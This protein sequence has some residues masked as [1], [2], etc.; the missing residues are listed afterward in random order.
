MKLK[1]VLSIIAMLL[2]VF[3]TGCE[4][5]ID[6][7]GTPM[8]TSTNPANNSTQVAINRMV[9]V[10]FSEPMDISTIT[11]LTFTLNQGST[12]V[13]GIV[14][15]TGTSATF[16][17]TTDLS[18]SKIYSGTITTGVKNEAGVAMLSNHTFIFTTG[19]AADNILPT[20]ISN[21]PLNNATAVG[22][23]KGVS[24]NFSEAMDPSTLNSSF[25]LKQGTTA[26]PG[27]VTYTGSTATFT[28]TNVLA[29]STVYTATVTTGAKDLAGNALATNIVWSFTTS[30]AL[31]G[32]SAVNLGTAADFVIL[33]KTKISTTGTS[34]V[35]GNIGISPAAA[36]F[37]TGFALILPAGGAFSTSS[38]VTGN[39]YA[40]N[41]ASPTPANMTTAISNMQTAYTDAAGRTLPDFTELYTGN[42]GGKTL[43]PGLYKWSSTVLVPSSITLSGSA[44]DVWIFQISKDLTVSN[45]VNVTLSGGAS[46]NN[47]F[48]Q[49]AGIATLGTTSHFEGNILCKT[50][51]TFKTGASMNGRALAQ[52][53]VVLDANAV[54]KP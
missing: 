52:T 39:I 25:T 30:G 47:I 46:A 4:K 23:D 40:P 32:L 26:V 31:A 48:W 19:A 34:H 21:S 8:V 53:A 16:T 24:I 38:L 14:T 20:V 28:P 44:T 6:T 2:I 50:G 37:I 54:T 29:A 42:I 49:V 18:L 5:K 1:S 12:S 9:V 36:T 35:T 45:A 41:Y 13:P 33:A 7:S 3:I 10:E 51:I 22:R 17:P 11:G 15:Y 43:V 27:T